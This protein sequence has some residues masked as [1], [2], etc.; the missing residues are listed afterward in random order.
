MDYD[1]LCNELC[2]EIEYEYSSRIED[3]KK[4]ENCID[5]SGVSDDE[6]DDTRKVLIVMT[7]AYFE[8]FCKKALL[9]YLDYINKQKLQVKQVKSSLAASS[10]KHDF[11]LLN[12]QNHKPDEIK[13]IKISDDAKLFALSRRTEFV[14]KYRH[15]MDE[16]VNLEESVI[17][18]ESNLKSSVLKGLLYKL[19]LDYTIVDS[20]QGDLNKLIG[21]RHSIAHGEMV[22]GIDKT[23]YCEYKQNAVVLMSN[24]KDI[25]INS[26]RSKAYLKGT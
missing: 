25:I 23:K 6:K 4:F 8:G 13:G 18:T 3:L 24:V 12:N 15:I 21:I 17:D 16:Y 9:I 11:D 19:D 2:N 1:I 7:Y 5:L 22:R 10:V 14:E 20:F 26:F